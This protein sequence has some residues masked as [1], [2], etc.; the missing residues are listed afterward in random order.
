M[1]SIT[2]IQIP[3]RT[4]SVSGTA[5]GETIATEQPAWP[6]Q[7]PLN[8]KVKSITA[9]SYS[10]FGDQVRMNTAKRNPNADF[11]RDMASINTSLSQRQVPLG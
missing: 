11:A 5:F 3:L 6:T 7:E 8:Y 10:S 1:S 2:L 9:S 4:N